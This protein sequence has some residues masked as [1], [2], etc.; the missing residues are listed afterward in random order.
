MGKKDKL[1]KKFSAQPKDFTYEELAALLN[2]LGFREERTGHATGSAV[3]FVHNKLTLE[4]EGL[5]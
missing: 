5:L 3:C 2:S 4:K 1:K